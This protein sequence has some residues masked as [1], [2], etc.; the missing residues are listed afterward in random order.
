MSQ[1]SSGTFKMRTGR[2]ASKLRDP[3]VQC[4]SAIFHKKE[5]R[6]PVSQRNIPEEGNP[7]SSVTA[8]YSR[9]R[10]PDFQCHSAIFQKKEI[11]FPVSQRNIPEDGNP[12]VQCHSAIFQKEEE[13]GVILPK[14][15]SFS[16]RLS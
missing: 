5:I 3:I 6:F 1:N 2:F 9:R 14:N 4:H 8:Q 12:I 10:K 13:M 16:H 7:I 11:R 15:G